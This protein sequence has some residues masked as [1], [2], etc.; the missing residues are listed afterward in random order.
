M[1]VPDPAKR[2]VDILLALRL[3]GA[4]LFALGLTR[5]VR[6]HGAPNPVA[7]LILLAGFALLIGIPWVLRR[8]WR[9]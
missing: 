5:W 8:R 6:G 9:G 1:S 4:V 7:A 2:R 3:A